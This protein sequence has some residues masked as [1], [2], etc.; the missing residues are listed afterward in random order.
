MTLKPQKLFSVVLLLLAA[1]TL[2][3]FLANAPQATSAQALQGVNRK[4]A[5]S[6]GSLRTMTT[7]SDGSG[8]QTLIGDNFDQTTTTQT[9]SSSS[10][11]VIS[12]I[13]GGGGT[14]G[15]TFNTNFIELFN[16]GTSTVDLNQ[17]SI[18]ITT[19]N[20]TAIVGISFVSSNSIPLMP[21]QY[22]LVGVGTPTANGQPVNADFPIPNPATIG[23]SGQVMLMKPNANVPSGVPCPLPNSGIADFVG[24]GNTATCSEGS[25]PV[26]T[27]SNT[28]AALRK[29]GGCTDS[30]SNVGDFTVSA[31]TPR[32]L[33]STFHS[34]NSIDDVDFFVKQH[35]IDFLNRQADASGLA[36]WKND[37]LQCGTDTVCTEVKRINVSAAFYLSIEFQQTGYL[38]Y[39]T[40]KAAYGLIPGTPVPIRLTEFLPDTQQ[41]GQNLI[42]GNPGWEA[43][44]ESNKVAYLQDFVT[45]QRFTTAYPTS[46]TPTAFVDAL[47]ANTGITPSA[48]DRN[49]AINEFGGA[50]T[51]ADSAARGRALRRVAENVLFSNA[52]TNRAFVLMQYFGYL[53]RNPND[54]PEQNLDFGGYN[55]W[56]SKLNQFN[57]NFIQAEMVKAFLDSAEYRHRFGS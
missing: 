41:I 55:F 23:T 18:R 52:E 1:I 10:S 22:A 5:F 13:Y 16:R 11:V 4:I 48:Q 46:L 53:R 9:P 33:T 31:P 56:L 36:F 20:G 32:G 8:H 26:P 39:R 40:Y 27:L 2:V 6:S 28:T 54:P 17:W 21:G 49:D 15:A 7:N 25:G 38:V 44:L 19:A 3:T 51:T 14:T 35:Y 42:V 34:C 47:F 37:I 12:Q 24:F 43:Q 50:G 30:D 57:G 45:R 29:S